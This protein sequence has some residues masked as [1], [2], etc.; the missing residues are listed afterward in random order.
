MLKYVKMLISQISSLKHEKLH[1]KGKIHVNI[2]K[3]KCDTYS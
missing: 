3:I 1:Y 2:D